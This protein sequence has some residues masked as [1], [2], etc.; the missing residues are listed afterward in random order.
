MLIIIFMKIIPPFWPISSI[1][2]HFQRPRWSLLGC[3]ETK[4]EELPP[5][6]RRKKADAQT[7]RGTQRYRQIGEFLGEWLDHLPKKLPFQNSLCQISCQRICAV[8]RSCL[9]WHHSRHNW[10]T[11][12]TCKRR[13]RMR[14]GA[15][16]MW[17]HVCRWLEDLEVVPQWFSSGW[18]LWNIV[19]VS[20]NLTGTRLPTICCK[21]MGGTNPTNTVFLGSYT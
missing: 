8:F 21:R 14:W 17:F 11:W 2:S 1:S 9:S 4:R 18:W 12:E 19:V 13:M 20:S 6:N 3:Q 5:A 16:A 15:V 10:C 7:V